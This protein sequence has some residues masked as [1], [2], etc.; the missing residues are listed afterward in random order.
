MDALEKI[1]LEK[2]TEREEAKKQRDAVI[3]RRKEKVRCT[4][5]K[6]GAEVWRR[7]WNIDEH[8]MI[9]KIE[10]KIMTSRVK[11]RFAMKTILI[12]TCVANSKEG[13]DNIQLQ[14]IAELFATE[15]MVTLTGTYFTTNGEL[16]KL[17][18]NAYM[19]Y[20]R[21]M[22]VLDYLDGKFG[23]CTLVWNVRNEDELLE[24]ILNNAKNK[25]DILTILM[26]QKNRNK[27]RSFG[28]KDVEYYAIKFAG[29]HFPNL[30]FD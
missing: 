4:F 14:D 27:K 6:Y 3:Q 17:K 11:Y 18:N 12:E 5:N 29:K 20:S 1:R 7:V 9:A 19:Q 26:D 15:H 10:E 30:K 25:E 22:S 23:L 13:L 8:D 16:F 24:K 28:E 2:E 21:K